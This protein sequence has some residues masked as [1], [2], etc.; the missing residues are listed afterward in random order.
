M[1][2]HLYAA[3]KYLSQQKQS[4]GVINTTSSVQFVNL[5]LKLSLVILNIKATNYISAVRPLEGWSC[6][7]PSFR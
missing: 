1:G 7:W 2:K 3:C 5:L 4:Y 6:V